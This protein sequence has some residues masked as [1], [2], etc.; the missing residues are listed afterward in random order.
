LSQADKDIYSLLY[1]GMGPDLHW[2]PEDVPLERL[3]T[4]FVGMANSQGGQVLIGI[5]PRSGV[6][7]GISDHAGAVDK[8]FQAALL[9]DPTLI[10]PLPQQV[11]VGD[12]VIL[13]ISVPAGLPHVYSLGG[14]YLY[15]EGK[16]T[17][18]IPARHLRQMLLERGVAQFERTPV[19]DCG[20]SDLDQD[21]VEA[22]YAVFVSAFGEPQLTMPTD[23]VDLLIQRGCLVH[24]GRKLF[25]TNAGLLLFGKHPQRW[26]PGA[27][28]LAARFAGN[29]L[30]DRFI[31]QEISGSLSIQLREIERFIR[32]N[33]QSVVR[34][35][36]LTRQETLEYPFE[37]VREL[38]VN[39]IAHRDY[40]IQGD[41][42]HLNIFADRLEVISPG[43]LPGPMT[44][45][46][47][48][49]ARFSRNPVIAQV[50]SDMGF[51]E[52][53]GYGLNRVMGILR[54]YAL[55]P[56]NF[57][58]VAGTFKVTLLNAL[59]PEISIDN[60]ARF[61]AL[62]LN[63]RQIAA[64]AYLATHRRITSG[65]YQA[66]CPEVH[67]ETLRRDLIDLISKGV[68]LK[69]GDKRATYYIFK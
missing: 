27:H 54:E 31:K 22:Y 55:Q 9:T 11:V 62:D 21:Q 53:L 67:A 50:L 34:L 8:V 37:A 58:E 23:P 36:G 25:P 16:Q 29:H 56:P 46:N 17:N 44:L 26:F 7:Q 65:Q 61:Q 69:I 59:S 52:R 47:L 6:I 60:L 51:I 3:A 33:L 38:M 32:M 35:V 15:R 1:Q 28:V 57:E 42:I 43:S 4:T 10:I 41:G 66:L 40:N 13:Q 68:L 48:L 24:D 12:S 5:S 49:E 18:P 45:Q 14:R 39:A 2:F 30:G 63:P 64:L 19:P 20:L